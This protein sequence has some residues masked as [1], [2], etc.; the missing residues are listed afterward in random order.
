M[1]KFI[2]ASELMP[3]ADDIMS[4]VCEKLIQYLS[5]GM[6]TTKFL[7]WFELAFWNRNHRVVSISMN[8]LGVFFLCTHFFMRLSSLR[9]M[10]Y[11]SI[12]WY[13]RL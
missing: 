7:D 9:L 8:F 10:A 12:S 6:T 13:F 11:H 4:L 1:W 2:R 5:L 3:S